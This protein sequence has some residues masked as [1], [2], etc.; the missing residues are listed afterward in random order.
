PG[1]RPCEAW[2]ARLLS[3]R[4]S[5]SLRRAGVAR[6]SVPR[7][8]ENF[9]V[10]DVLEVGAW[11]RAALELPDQTVVR[12]DQG[13]IISFAAPADDKRTWLDILKGAIHVISRDPR[14]LR[15]ITPFANAGI[16]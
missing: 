13:T 10:G 5:L 7:L 8:N 1:A 2:V 11:S 9:C 6:V 12:I 15:V 16:E 3:S 14:A 4:G